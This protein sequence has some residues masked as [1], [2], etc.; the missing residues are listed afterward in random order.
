M[1]FG[2]IPLYGRVVV[3]AWCKGCQ[4]ATPSKTCAKCNVPQAACAA[5]GRCPA[6]DG[7]IVQ[8]DG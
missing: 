5:C 7:P 4:H 3:T 8:E 2:E 1:S 6:C